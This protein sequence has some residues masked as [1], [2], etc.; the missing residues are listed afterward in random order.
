MG[1]SFAAA[2]PPGWFL[3]RL[4]IIRAIMAK[5]VKAKGLKVP[6]AAIPVPQPF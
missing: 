2:L 5:G 4:R 1:R 3:S 6:S